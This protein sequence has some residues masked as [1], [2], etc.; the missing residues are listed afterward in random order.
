MDKRYYNTNHAHL[1][2]ILLVSISLIIS[3]GMTRQ[4]LRDV[5]LFLTT[6]P[7]SKHTVFGEAEERLITRREG[8]E[9]EVVDCHCGSSARSS[10]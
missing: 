1:L 9:K 10:I 2:S 3:L 7:Y 8:G 6:V 5:S 4:N